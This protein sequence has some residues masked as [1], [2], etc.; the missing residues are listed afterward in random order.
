MLWWKGGIKGPV[1]PKLHAEDG[2]LALKNHQKA[3]LRKRWREGS[4]E[5]KNK[6]C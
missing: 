6:N 1:V 4:Q 3:W 5:Q 2:S